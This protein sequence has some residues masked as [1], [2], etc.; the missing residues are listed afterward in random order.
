MTYGRSRSVGGGGGKI[1]LFLLVLVLAIGGCG[2]Y[3]YGTVEDGVNITVTEK[4]R[5][6]KYEDSKYL[7]FTDSET[8]QNSDAIFH[9]KFNSSDLYGQLKVGQTY[10]A[11]VFGWR[12]PFLSMYRNIVSAEQVSGGGADAEYVEQ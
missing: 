12:V 7:V 5:V 11:K 4:E 6:N 10:K 8:F 1:L 3:Q 2:M 9:G